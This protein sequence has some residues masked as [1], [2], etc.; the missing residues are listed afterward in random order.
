TINKVWDAA[1]Q[2]LGGGPGMPGGGFGGGGFGTPTPGGVVT[3]GL[4][5]DLE[6]LK[7]VLEELIALGEASLKWTV[8]GLIRLT[9][10]VK[11]TYST[12]YW[13]EKIAAAVESWTAPPSAAP[14][15]VGAPGGSGA[16]GAAGGTVQIESVVDRPIVLTAPLTVQVAPGEDPD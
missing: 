11:A 13:T 9:D 5:V 2:F 4:R 8:E 3:L 12:A 16:A 6:P 7:G 14:A 10:I 15:F 1:N